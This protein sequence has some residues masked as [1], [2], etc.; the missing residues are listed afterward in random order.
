MKKEHVTSLRV[1]YSETDAIGIVYHTNY[2]NYMERARCDWL[3]DIG[4]P[5]NLLVEEKKI[6]FAVKDI[7]ISYKLPARLDDE[8]FVRSKIFKLGRASLSYEQ[9]IS[10]DPNA[11]Q[12]L[13]SAKVKIVCLDL[14][15]KPKVLPLDLHESL[16]GVCCDL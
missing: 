2:I 14:D 5:I 1:Y 3:R 16:K 4:F 15:L 11:D 8:I 12:I 6:L 10:K 7:D 13:C 9:V